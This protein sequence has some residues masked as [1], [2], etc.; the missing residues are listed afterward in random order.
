MKKI[1]LLLFALILSVGIMDAQTV[2]PG[3]VPVRAKQ[4]FRDSTYFYKDA[5][6][7]GP[8]RVREGYFK[9]GTVTISVNGDEVNILDGLL[10]NTTE[11]NYSVG[12]TGNIQTQINSRLAIADTF[13]MLNNY[14][15]NGHTHD[16]SDLTMSE[17]DYAELSDYAVLLAD[18]TLFKTFEWGS[19]LIKDTA[20]F[21]NGAIKSFYNAGSDTL[22]VTSLMGVMAEGAGTESVGVQVSWHTTLKSGSAT[23]LNASAYTVTSTTTGNEDIA[24]ANAKIPPEN[25]VWATLS[26]ITSGNKPSYLAVNLSGYR[27]PGIASSVPGDTCTYTQNLVKY[28]ET[29]DNGDGWY[30]GSGSSVT[31][32]NAE[33]DL[34]GNA[35]LEQITTITNTASF[36]NQIP[37]NAITVIPGTTYRFSFDVK[38]GT[39]T[40]LSYSVYNATGAADIVAPTSYYASVGATVTRISVEFTAPAGCTSVYVYPLRES[41]VTG[42][43][44]IG[45]V[46]VEENGSCYVETT[47]SIIT[48]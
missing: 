42:T 11:L 8:V 38:K 27:I 2:G 32:T 36:R 41:D 25:F 47:S 13:P 33:Y 18:T 14:S 6:F 43:V 7:Y 37:V 40:D 30:G 21:Y 3:W 12:L 34:E 29:L 28:S 44:Y 39:M 20:D 16:L 31:A 45:R 5:S 15:R 46:Q 24:F 1:L 35:T 10:T 23:N 17:G 9:I 4:N 19:G 26:G 48:P 22:A